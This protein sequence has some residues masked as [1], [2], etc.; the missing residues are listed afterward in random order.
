M[1]DLV[2]A[3]FVAVVLNIKIS[4]EY[5]CYPT[6][7]SG[8]TSVNIVEK[9]LKVRRTSM[10]TPRFTQANSADTARFAGKA[11]PRSTIL[12]FTI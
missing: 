5:T 11:S 7:R 1:K 10:N 4:S 12:P 8:D 2:Y 9:V 3:I 6:L